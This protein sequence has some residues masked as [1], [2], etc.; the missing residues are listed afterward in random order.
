MSIHARRN[1][2]SG[3][4]V[5]ARSANAFVDQPPRQNTLPPGCPRLTKTKRTIMNKSVSP[6][7]DALARAFHANEFVW[8]VT[9]ISPDHSACQFSAI[10]RLSAY[11]RRLTHVLGRWTYSF[12]IL[13]DTGSSRNRRMIAECILFLPGVGRFRGLAEVSTDARAAPERAKAKAFQSACIKAGVGKRI[14][15]IW[16]AINFDGEPKCLPSAPPTYRHKGI[17]G[18]TGSAS[19]L[20]MPHPSIQLSSRVDDTS[21]IP[22]RVSTIPRHQAPDSQRRTEVPE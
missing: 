16:I 14:E 9:S 13:P 2:A 21:A 4:S 11:R 5:T 6:L 8:R 1:P 10:V 19:C 20:S 12:R 15:P 17:E 3:I 7:C 18:D 22:E